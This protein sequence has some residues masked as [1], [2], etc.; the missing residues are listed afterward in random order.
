MP[1]PLEYKKTEWI[2]RA[3]PF[4]PAEELC[5]SPITEPNVS[6]AHTSR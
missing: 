4:S 3:N 2:W 1:L 6:A 5:S